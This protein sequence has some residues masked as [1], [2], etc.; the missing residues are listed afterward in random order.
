MKALDENILMVVFMLLLNRVHVF[1]IFTLMFLLF[2]CLI[3]TEKH[4]SQR[5]NPYYSAKD[6]CLIFI[7]QALSKVFRQLVLYQLVFLLTSWPTKTSLPVLYSTPLQCN[8]NFHHVTFYIN[9]L[10][11]TS[12]AHQETK[13]HIAWMCCLTFSIAKFS[14]LYDI[15]L[16]R[17]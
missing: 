11:L 12:L 16:V 5:V 13:N 7:L 2:L 14:I 10:N 15:S 3:L 6:S 1:A 8:Q 9:I 4:G 17:D